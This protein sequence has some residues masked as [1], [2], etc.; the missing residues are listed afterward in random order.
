M[1]AC[2]WASLYTENHR[3][4][5]KPKLHVTGPVAPPHQKMARLHNITVAFRQNCVR[6]D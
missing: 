6:N 4:P 1:W 3:L 2:A 5:F